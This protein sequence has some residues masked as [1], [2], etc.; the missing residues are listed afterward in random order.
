MDQPVATTPKTID[1]IDLNL[2]L[3]GSEGHNINYI[4]RVRSQYLYAQH[5]A[6]ITQNQ[7]ADAK[8]AAL[9]TLIGLLVLR[10]PI[11][12]SLN[13]PPRPFELGFG[14]AALLSIVFS[15][16]AVFP[17]I[18]S[19]KVRAKM[20]K[21]DR[22]SWP[23]ISDPSLPPDEFAKFMQT[24]EVSQLIYS[25]ALSNANV[26]RILHRKFRYLQFAIIA[27][28]LTLVFLSIHVV[29]PFLH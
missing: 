10:G 24:S 13:L 15:L 21:I 4:A 2:D 9:I 20:A 14:I 22:W 25:V 19:N 17:R 28:G 23:A 26:A 6:L 29:F 16:I 1:D 27:A 11:D 8:A 3:T 5:Q 12:G 7:F 18:P